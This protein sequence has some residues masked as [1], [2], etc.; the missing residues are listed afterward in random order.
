MS[1][2]FEIWIRGPLGCAIHLVVWNTNI[3]VR[4]MTPHLS[5]DTMILILLFIFLDLITANDELT[6]QPSITTLVPFTR[7]LPVLLYAYLR[8]IPA[9]VII[10]PVQHTYYARSATVGNDKVGDHAW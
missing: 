10:K 3:L 5:N 1:Q 2:S 8:P 9:N 4:T 7:E 6:P